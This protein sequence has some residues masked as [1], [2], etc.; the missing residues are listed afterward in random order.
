MPT[1]ITKEEFSFVKKGTIL[2]SSLE[3][4]WIF[5]DEPNYHFE[6]IEINIPER[7]LSSPS[8]SDLCVKFFFGE[9]VS[10][11]LF[12]IFELNTGLEKIKISEE[13]QIENLENQQTKGEN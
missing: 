12:P 6:G 9:I 3:E 8:G 2:L 4:E 1:G 10:E 7:F 5:L 11:E 13:I